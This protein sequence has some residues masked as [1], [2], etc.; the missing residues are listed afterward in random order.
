VYSRLVRVLRSEI[1]FT[2]VFPRAIRLLKRIPP[3]TLDV[4]N[5]LSQWSCYKSTVAIT[6]NWIEEGTE[7]LREATDE[8]YRVREVETHTEITRREKTVIRQELADAAM[9]RYSQEEDKV[10]KSDKDFQNLIEIIK[11]EAIR[12]EA[13][14]WKKME[15]KRAKVAAEEKE[16]LI[17]AQKAHKDKKGDKFMDYR[18]TYLG[19][20][21]G[22]TAIAG[23][24]IAIMKGY[25]YI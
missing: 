19:I 5:S 8:Q 20:V 2:I 11:E 12:E 6:H 18:L 3:E 7:L 23:A 14:K 13:I 22:G 15:V 9:K 1:P 25:H 4:Y 24:I 21:I 16:R 10:K 17:L